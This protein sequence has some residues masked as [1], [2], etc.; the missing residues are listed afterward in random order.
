MQKVENDKY[1]RLAQEEYTKEAFRERFSS[2]KTGKNTLISDLQEIACRY[3]KYK[4]IKCVWDIYF[5]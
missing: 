2:R 4:G 1:T 5:D 3:R